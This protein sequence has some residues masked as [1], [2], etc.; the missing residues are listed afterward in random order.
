MLA[1]YIDW[2]SLVPRFKFK[3]RGARNNAVPFPFHDIPIDLY[4]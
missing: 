3:R 2:A 1:Q 4:D